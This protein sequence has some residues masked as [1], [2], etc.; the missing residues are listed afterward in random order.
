M[1]VVWQ[2]SHEKICMHARACT[3][4]AKGLQ[5]CSRTFME[6]VWVWETLGWGANEGPFLSVETSLPGGPFLPITNTLITFFASFV[7]RYINANLCK[8]T[9]S[10]RLEGIHSG[11]EWQFL[12]V[13]QGAARLMKG[14]RAVHG[15]SLP[16]QLPPGSTRMHG[17]HCSQGAW[18]DETQ[19]WDLCPGTSP[20]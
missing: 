11:K 8:N 15:G 18:A 10:M 16:R 13:K 1:Y 19:L 20:I 17:H 5:R 2:L 9:E 4:L 12:A 6:A 14:P 7:T 3:S